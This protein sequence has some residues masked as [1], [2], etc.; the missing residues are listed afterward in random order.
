MEYDT[1]P[2]HIA[3]TVPDTHWF[4]TEDWPKSA[5][6]YANT[7]KDG[8]TS[9]AKKYHYKTQISKIKELQ[10]TKNAMIF[11]ITSTLNIQDIEVMHG[12]SH[13]NDL[14][15]LHTFH[16]Y[17]LDPIDWFLFDGLWI[18]PTSY[19]KEFEN[20]QKNI[21]K[22]VESIGAGYILLTTDMLAIP[23]LNQFF[24]NRY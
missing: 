9:S 17:E 11:Y 5:F 24:K 4:Y 19:K 8:I 10:Q 12:I 6:E 23:Y 1:F 14:I 3:Q 7:I 16:P 2:I 18:N 13:N 20:K 22:L 15:V 21:K